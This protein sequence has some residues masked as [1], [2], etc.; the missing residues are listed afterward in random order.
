MVEIFENLNLNF[1]G[2]NTKKKQIILTHTG[3]PILDYIN[4]LKTRTNGEYHKIPNYVISREGLIYQC[5]SDNDYSNFF[6][7]EEINKNS[8]IISL[9]NLG[10]LEK[11]PLTLS[12]NNWIRSIY[13]GEIYER[14]WRDYFFW[15]P[16]T[17]EQIN[18]TAKICI[19]LL[20]KFSIDKKCIGHN[21][22]V[23]G[24]ENFKGI[25]TRSNFNSKFTDLSPA[26]NFENFLKLIENE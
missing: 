14:K 16:Y 6:K 24:V 21:T 22:K 1:L 3:R 18:V 7:K 11:T 8:I 20:D 5:I 2:K 17:E 12:Y 10:W 23:D 25:V 19:Y 9:E 13:N 15:Q 4:S 26:F